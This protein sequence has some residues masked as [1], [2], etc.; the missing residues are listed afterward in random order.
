MPKD[1]DMKIRNT[2]KQSKLLVY[3][4]GKWQAIPLQKVK[5]ANNVVPSK[6]LS[7]RVRRLQLSRNNSPEIIAGGSG[8]TNAIGVIPTPISL[9]TEITICQT[10]ASKEYYTLGTGF[11]GQKKL[12]IHKPYT[13]KTRVANETECYIKCDTA[14]KTGQIFT[15]VVSS[16]ND[17]RTGKILQLVSDGEVWYPYG[18]QVD[19][20]DASYYPGTWDMS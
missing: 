12:I 4:K 16:S 10:E 15:S 3:Y 7:K 9:K 1:F 14:L 8:W 11:I 6:M 19:A 20:N 5:E 17:E 13:A 2:G 18:G